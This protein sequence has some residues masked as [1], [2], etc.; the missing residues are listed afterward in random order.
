[1]QLACSDALCRAIKDKHSKAV[2][3]G[4]L[5]VILGDIFSNTIISVVS[6]YFPLSGATSE[7]RKFT[8]ATYLEAET[9]DPPINVSPF[10]AQ[11]L[12]TSPQQAERC[13]ALTIVENCL[14]SLCQVYIAE[15]SKLSKYPSFDKLWIKIMS[16]LSYFLAGESKSQFKLRVD[17]AQMVK[18]CEEK[19]QQLLVAMEQNRIFEVREG[20][21]SVTDGII[22]HLSPNE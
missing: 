9:A 10:L 15:L 4:V 7:M 6:S 16:V 12:V 14:E 3:A 21:R 22:Q 1:M 19:L 18:L 11:E 13:V 20:L 2:P 8:N 17:S 5:V